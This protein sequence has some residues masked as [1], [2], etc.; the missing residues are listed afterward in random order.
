MY[1]IKVPAA[2]AGKAYGATDFVG[3]LDK[4]TGIY[5]VS[6]VPRQGVH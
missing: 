6:K 5:K 2:A 4:V 1:G 3:Q